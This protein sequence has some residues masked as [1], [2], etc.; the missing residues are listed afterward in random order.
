MN[1]TFRMHDPRV[2]RFFATDPL[3]SKFPFYSPYQFS[4]NSPIMSIELEGLESSSTGTNVN[5]NGDVL[6]DYEYN[7]STSPPGELK[8]VEIVAKYKGNRINSETGQNQ[9]NATWTPEVTNQYYPSYTKDEYIQAFGIEKY[10]QYTSQDAVAFHNWTLDKTKE[11]NDAELLFKLSLFTGKF[12]EIAEVLGPVTVLH[13]L[14]GFSSSTFTRKFNYKLRFT[15]NN[16]YSKYGFKEISSIDELKDAKGL[17]IFDDALKYSPYVGKSNNSVL[18][19]LNSH[20]KTGKFSKG[21]KVYFKPLIGNPTQ[22]EVQETIMINNLGGLESTANKILPVS[23][24]R[25]K[26]LQLGITNYSQFG[27]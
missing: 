27:N 11:S 20:I 26:Q 3:E 17:Y 10:Y 13:S 9:D 24:K 2:G 4:S 8:E 18:S 22:F 25:N 14:K 7:F 15:N 19:R 23:V 6:K 1:Y 5:E 16:P 12:T 21:S